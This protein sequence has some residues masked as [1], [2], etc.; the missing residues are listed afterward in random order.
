MPGRA[1]ELSGGWPDVACE[2]MAGDD[3]KLQ[4]GRDLRCYIRTLDDARLL[5]R[6][7]RPQ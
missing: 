2:S 3:L 4:A 6:V 7:E 1:V 5:G